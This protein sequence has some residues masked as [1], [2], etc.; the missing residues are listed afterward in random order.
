MLSSGGVVPLL[1]SASVVGE[2]V[3]STGGVVPL[4][5]S[6]SV[7]GEQVLSSVTAAMMEDLRAHGF[8][9]EPVD[10]V[11]LRLPDYHALVRTPMDL[12]TVRRERG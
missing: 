5:Y 9:S 4:L 7:V 11:K 2:Q 10:A 6:A 12:G 8:F 1:N 3:L